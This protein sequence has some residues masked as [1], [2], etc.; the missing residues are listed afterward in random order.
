MKRLIVHIGHGKT[1]S[2]FLQSVFALNTDRMA[3]LGIFYPKHRSNALAQ[4]GFISS[5]NGTILLE[6]SE[7][8]T[9]HPNMLFSS[10]LL[11]K[12]LLKKQAYIA[13]LSRLYDLEVIIYLRDVIDHRISQW[14]QW[15]KRSGFCKDLDT[16]LL[17][18][19]YNILDSVLKWIDLSNEVGFKLI[20]KNYTKCKNN[21]AQDFFNDVLNAP[22]HTENLSLPD[23]TV[24]RSLSL[25]ELEIQRVFNA[26]FG[27]DSSRYV[28]DFLCNK[29]P[30]VKPFKPVLS[31]HTYDK[32][33]SEYRAKVDA[34]NSVIDDS[35]HLEIGSREHYV[36]GATEGLET[37]DND[38]CKELGESIR[39][40]IKPDNDSS[41]DILRDVALRIYNKNPAAIEDA[42]A[43][44]KIALRFRPHGP[45]IKDKVAQ[46]S[47]LLEPTEND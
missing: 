33:V 34:I 24:N 15:I 16:F 45:H 42:L 25:I 41:A 36:N 18:K 1:G 46:W 23:I 35:M 31:E 26:A 10:E 47:A 13:E 43:L 39:Q 12:E 6:T 7:F 29:F 9:T 30:D 22:S 40:A 32:I 3:E 2:S 38:L 19:S 27:K 44:M 5:G 17:T 4:S 8:D 37:L 28:S 11:F 21:L 20:L 14:G